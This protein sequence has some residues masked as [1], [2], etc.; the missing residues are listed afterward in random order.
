MGAPA[1][2]V[3]AG[4]TTCATSTKCHVSNAA[5]SGRAST[6]TRYPTSL[7]AAKH[8]EK[9]DGAEPF[10]RDRYVYTAVVC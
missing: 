4:Q 2:T 10:Q 1:L 9:H 7:R 3:G 5:A 8:W 6:L